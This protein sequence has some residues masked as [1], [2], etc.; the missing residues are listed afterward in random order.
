[1]VAH[2]RKKI[3]DKPFIGERRKI[4]VSIKL[5]VPNKSSVIASNVP[6]VDKRPPYSSADSLNGDDD[7]P[8]SLS[9]TGAHLRLKWIFFSTISIF[10][11]ISWF[12]VP[13]CLSHISNSG[14]GDGKLSRI[15][16]DTFFKS[17]DK[18]GD[19]ILKKTE[20]A[21][22]VHDLVGG[23]DFDT[24]NEVNLEVD[25]VMENLDRDKDHGLDSSDVYAYWDN[26]KSL[27]TTEEVKEWIIHSVQLPE[28]VGKKFLE[29]G[30]TGYDFPELVENDGALLRDDVGISK[31]AQRKKILRQI[32]ARL[33]GIG[34][35]PDVIRNKDVTYIVHE[36]CS[37]VQF[38]WKKT[39]AGG[40]PV[41]KYRVQRNSY[42]QQP[43]KKGN[44]SSE[45]TQKSIPDFAP[46][47]G[48]VYDTSWFT[49]YSGPDPQFHDNDIQQSYSHVYRIQAWNAVGRSPWVYIHVNNCFNSA[50]KSR[51]QGF[52]SRSWMDHVSETYFVTNLVITFSQI[53]GLL[54]FVAGSVMRFKRASV[55]STMIANSTLISWIPGFIK[56]KIQLCFGNVLCELKNEHDVSV[57]A[58][59]LRGYDKGSKS[60]EDFSEDDTPN[61]RRMKFAMKKAASERS[62]NSVGSSSRNSDR[63]S[64]NFRHRR[65]SQNLKVDAILETK[66]DEL[67][68]KTDDVKLSGKKKMRN[69]ILSRMKRN[70][71]SIEEISFISDQICPPADDYNKCNTCNK[72]Y[73]IFKRHKHHCARCM[74]TFCHKHG[75][76]TH[77]NFTSCKVPGDC[78]CNH[79][80]EDRKSVV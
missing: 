3:F 67:Y 2:E 4:P 61:D 8:F 60:A 32:N 70:K 53:L 39:N 76:V 10:V 54:L 45:N 14:I 11:M 78:L 49:V 42:F 5:H 34:S 20:V 56:K 13:F 65:K 12:E 63:E 46:I 62:L 30:V 55:P 22:F 59:N 75:R 51:S 41:H 25:K 31:P 38:Q 77:S 57:R 24:E 28:H 79:C 7:V 58:T 68:S 18:D 80:L 47:S 9:L 21:K 1:M 33:L 66:S 50:T 35:V 48:N 44:F 74:A 19:G 36:N 15:S 69:I 17:V 43:D 6:K 29:N 37:S 72:H 52:K 71:V 64:S 16:A 26:L 23:K 73:K 27:L 40:F